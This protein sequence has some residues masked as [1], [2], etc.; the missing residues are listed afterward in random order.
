METKKTSI[1]SNIF[2]II[3]LLIWIVACFYL[4]VG[5]F[6]HDE[7]ANNV[8]FLKLFDN[9][10]TIRY[11]SFPDEII[12][13]E[14]RLKCDDYKNLQTCPLNE[15]LFC[16]Q[17][18]NYG[19]RCI[20]FEKD[21]SIILNSG[22]T[23][24]IVKNSNKNEGYCIKT[25]KPPEENAC[26]PVTGDYILI[27]QSVDS[28]F[29]GWAC[30]CKYPNLITQAYLGGNC[31]VEIACGDEGKLNGTI[32]D[33]PL[34]R[35][36][37][38]SK[39]DIGIN[40]PSF[41]SRCRMRT[42]FELED[43]SRDD[44]DEQPTIPASVLTDEFVEKLQYPDRIKFYEPCE[45][46]FKIIDDK[47]LYCM[48]EDFEK[49]M[50]EPSNLGSLFLPA[51]CSGS[52]FQKEKY[53]ASMLTIDNF[54]TQQYGIATQENATIDGQ[55]AVGIN[56][57][58]ITSMQLE[59]LYADLKENLGNRQGFE[60]TSMIIWYKY[61]PEELVKIYDFNSTTS[62]LAYWIKNTKVKYY[63]VK[64]Q[65][66][67]I[68]KYFGSVSQQP[69][70]IN[71]GYLHNVPTTLKNFKEIHTNQFGG[72]PY[73]TKIP[74]ARKLPW[75]ARMTYRSTYFGDFSLHA[76]SMFRQAQQT[77]CFTHSFYT[78]LDDP[79]KIF[80]NITN[81][82]KANITYPG[83][84]YTFSGTSDV[85]IGYPGLTI[86]NLELVK[87]IRKNYDFSDPD[88]YRHEFTQI[89][90]NDDNYIVYIADFLTGAFYYGLTHNQENLVLQ[91]F[92]AL[93][94][95]ELDD[96]TKKPQI[97]KVKYINCDCTSKLFKLK[98]EKNPKLKKLNDTTAFYYYL[99]DEDE[100]N[101][102]KNFQCDL[103][104]LTLKE[105][106]HLSKKELNDA[107]Q[108]SL[109]SGSRKRKLSESSNGSS[110]RRKRFSS[111]NIL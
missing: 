62:Q 108:T 50:N 65:S 84:L 41:G 55:T 89:W 34:S 99:I 63:S 73:A 69:T 105:L 10:N 39:Y 33:Y 88:K 70:A 83:L 102:I 30:K 17:C 4:S 95:W 36:C 91:S 66:T 96:E 68:E 15:A 19:N 106:K 67:S 72:F 49:Q 9:S 101:D 42:F 1:V 64:S 8:L 16:A 77:L 92:N 38:C 79:V 107:F 21:V 20:H 90:P 61:G 93:K 40:S 12:I 47:F 6:Q 53:P 25:D 26:N 100:Q 71:F 59:K 87:K 103:H 111:I 109:I 43:I 56:L 45:K 97:Y 94:D 86:N 46:N 60:A 18:N 48:N 85:Y 78:T 27:K 35:E 13:G 76:A 98:C 81:N 7:D 23:F 51:F 75:V 24:T 58:D 82:M 44:D 14:E 52:A 104:S 31:T 5:N 29:Y 54:V 110:K 80:F 2:T 37:T 22:E 57:V 3:F 11:K 28:E 74:N 32:D